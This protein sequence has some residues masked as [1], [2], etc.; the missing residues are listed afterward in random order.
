MTDFFFSCS[1]WSEHF[2]QVFCVCA[3]ACVLICFWY[4]PI[5]CVYP[6]TAFLAILNKFIRL[7]REKKKNVVLKNVFSCCSK[8]FAWWN[9]RVTLSKFIS[10]V[11]INNGECQSYWTFC[12]KKKEN[13]TRC[14][15]VKTICYSFFF[16]FLS[17]KSV[18]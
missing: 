8:Y 1:H 15:D 16:S 13:F 6:T 7:K 4:I 18:H 17:K 12:I 3:C 10:E 5:P 2:V 9:S 14:Q 11:V